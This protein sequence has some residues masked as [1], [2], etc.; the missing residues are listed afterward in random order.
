[1]ALEEETKKKN[2]IKDT[3]SIFDQNSMLI[4]NQ[5]MVQLMKLCNF[6]IN[7]KWR[8]LYRATNDGFLADD[9]HA[10][11]DGFKNTLTIIK[12][13]NSNIFGGYT[14]AEWSGHLVYKE[15]PNAFIFSLVN[16]DAE[17][18]IMRCSKPQF[19]IYCSH[20]FG[21]VFGLSPCDIAIEH[22]SNVKKSYSN[23]GCSYH[24]PKYCDGSYE[25]LTFLAGSRHF[26]AVDIEVYYKAVITCLPL[27]QGK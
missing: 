2:E 24:H 25:A 20:T 6:P 10:K 8:L 19:A 21:P 27:V 12:S 1:M 18:L 16:S 4:S 13:K 3:E 15:D 14:E 5:L 23:L 9:F 22:N 11:C 7:Q 17:P 26:Q